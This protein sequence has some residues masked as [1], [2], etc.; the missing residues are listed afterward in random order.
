MRTSVA[1]DADVQ[2][3]AVAA[4]EH[5]G[6]PDNEVLLVDERAPPCGEQVPARRA[7]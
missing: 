3:P 7:R 2:A 1:P 5:D 4:E 6:V